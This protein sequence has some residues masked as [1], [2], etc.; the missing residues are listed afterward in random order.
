[1]NIFAVAEALGVAGKALGGSWRTSSDFIS[2]REINGTRC[3]VHW[4]SVFKGQMPVLYSVFPPE[5]SVTR[6]VL[7]YL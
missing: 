7:P 5:C 6:G 4:K 2:R 3:E 1:M